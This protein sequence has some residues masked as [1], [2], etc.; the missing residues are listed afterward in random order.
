VLEGLLKWWC[1]WVSKVV[2]VSEWMS[3]Q[4]LGT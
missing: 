1:K 2:R 3:L 4:A